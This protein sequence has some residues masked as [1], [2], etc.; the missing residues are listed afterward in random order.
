[1][2]SRAGGANC[3]LGSCKFCTAQRI[4][5][6][7]EERSGSNNFTPSH[8]ESLIYQWGRLLVDPSILPYCFRLTGS[9]GFL[10]QAGRSY[11]FCHQMDLLH[12]GLDSETRSYSSQIEE[13]LEQTLGKSRVSLSGKQI[14]SFSKE[15]SAQCQDLYGPVVGPRMQDH[16]DFPA[17][18]TIIRETGYDYDGNQTVRVE[19]RAL[20]CYSRTLLDNNNQITI[21]SAPGFRA[22]DFSP[23]VLT[24]L[25]MYHEHRHSN[26]CKF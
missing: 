14:K 16:V 20:L 2:A 8:V 1:M 17:D 6:Q 19:V 21:N 26:P 23:D 15:F 5:R 12:M 22:S 10:H 3:G 11:V 25:Q 18:L 13:I 9:G 4:L 24:V 7:I